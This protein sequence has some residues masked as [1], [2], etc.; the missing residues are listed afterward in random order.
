MSKALAQYIRDL[1]GR[2]KLYKFYKSRAWKTLRQ[3]VLEENHFECARC[4]SVGRYTKA[5]MVHH[6]N[7]VKRR[8]DLALS[9]YFTDEHG[10]VKLNLLPLCDACH[11]REHQRFATGG[12]TDSFHQTHAHTFK[13]D[14]RW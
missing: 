1:E 12:A 7:E 6:V 3:Q 13:N 14:E 9:R 5:T 2:G 4:A 10:T 11:E 8:P